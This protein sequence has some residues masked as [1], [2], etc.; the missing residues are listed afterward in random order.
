MQNLEIKTISQE[1]AYN[2]IEERKNETNYLLFGYKSFQK[3]MIS[4]YY[5]EKK[6]IYSQEGSNQNLINIQ[7]NQE[8][9]DSIKNIILSNLPTIEDFKEILSIGNNF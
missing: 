8:L 1:E 2:I 9:K 3:G 7:D 6:L 4:V 5:D